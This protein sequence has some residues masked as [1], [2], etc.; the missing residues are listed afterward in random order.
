MVE[1]NNDVDSLLA[2]FDQFVSLSKINHDLFRSKLRTKKFAK[3]ELILL[4][5]NICK[6]VLFITKGL[7]RSY[8]TDFTGKTFTWYFHFNDRDA[9]F[10]NFFA[11]DFQSFL[12]QTPSM[13]TIEA[14][15]EVEGVVLEF[16]DAIALQPMHSDFEK[17][18]KLITEQAYITT[19]NRSL[20]LLTLSASLRYELLLANEPYLLNKFANHYIASYLGVTP[21]SLSRIRGEI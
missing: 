15:S 18:S 20:S 14:L 7:A 10:E 4:Q 1:D 9:N 19:H 2:F 11:I 17:Q 21:Q 13:I 6:Q 5:G 3:G 12:T 8:F 16:K